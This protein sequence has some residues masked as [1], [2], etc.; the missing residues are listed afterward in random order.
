M[1]FFRFLK[2]KT[3]IKKAASYKLIAWV[4]FAFLAHIFLFMKFENASFNDALWVSATT[5]VTV[6]YGDISAKTLEGRIA[7]MLLLYIGGIF[8]L[9]KLAG[10]WFSHLAMKAEKKFKGK[11]RYKMKNHIV[12]INHPSNNPQMF[13]HEFIHQIK[14]DERFTHKD[15]L[16]ISPEEEMPREL[17]ECG[18][19][20][21]HGKIHDVEAINKACVKDADSVIILANNA[22]D[23][24]FDSYALD[25]I[26]SIRAQGSNAY[27]VSE[28]VKPDNKRRLMKVG[29]DAVIKIM[30]G[31]PS[32]AARAITAKGSQEVLENLFSEEGEECIRIDLN[33][34]VE[35]S[36][37]DM[38]LQCMNQN[39]GIPIACIT[40]DNQILTSPLGKTLKMKALFVVVDGSQQ[41]PVLKL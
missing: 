30:H 36:W 21:V 1:I 6:G 23:T 15:I 41:I 11:W 9:A 31:F 5:I 20:W 33:T 2:N 18:M 34:I 10:D 32:A 16:L 4:I 14:R 12:I 7:T 35:K 13:L 40:E 24:S 27:I 28:C 25:I 17:Q 3:F 26:D 39:I 19:K 29:A 38:V 37:K 22:T 8:V